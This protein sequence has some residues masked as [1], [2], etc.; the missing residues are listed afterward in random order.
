MRSSH[1][2]TLNVYGLACGCDVADL[3]REI[4][5]MNGVESCSVDLSTGKMQVVGGASQPEIE[6]RL[7][8]LGYS[9][10]P[11]V[12]NGGTSGAVS[13]VVDFWRHMMR[14]LDTRLAVLSFFLL[15]PTL[16]ISEVLRFGHFLIA[17]FYLTSLSLA[18]WPVARSAWRALFH[19]REVNINVLMTIAS[20]GAV[21]I[22]SLGEAAVVMV[23]FALG[24]A[25]E[26][27]TTHRARESIRSLMQ[28]VPNRATRLERHGVHEHHI[29]VD[30][31]DLRIGD[32]ILVKPGERIPIDGQVVQGLSAV[33][34]APITGEARLI[35]KSAGD[36]VFASSVNG[37]GALEVEVSRLAEDTTINRMIRLVDQA[38]EKRAPTQRFIDRF[39]KAYTPAMVLAAALVALVPP[40]L[41]GE[42]LLNPEGGG[43]GWLY[44]GLALLVVGC[45]CALVISTPVTIISAIASAARQG[46][47][48]KG[49]AQLEKLSAVRAVAFDKTGTLTLGEPAV[50]AVRSLDC[51]DRLAEGHVGEGG[52]GCRGCDEVVALASAVERKSQHPIAD[53]IVRESQRRRVADRYPAAVDVV[54]RTGQGVQ[55]LIDEGEVVVGNHRYF[56]ES[57][58]HPESHCRAARMDSS[59]GRTPVMVSRDG[60]YIGTIT[61]ADSLRH[62]GLHA[63][64]T[65]R[66]DGI[67][68]LVML[69]GDEATSA[70]LIADQVG[71][72]DV[73]AGLLPEEKLNAVERLQLEYGRVA[74]VGDG[75]NDAPALA[76]ADVG[77]A[78][79]AASTA[80]HQAIETADVA[81]MSA[82]LSRLGFL[83]RLGRRTLGVIRANIALS[84]GLKAV[85][86]V[87]VLIGS[88]TMWMAV[89]ADM[90]ASLLV[91]LNGMRLLRFREV[92]EPN[93]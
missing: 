42:P 19:H 22:G 14:R 40:F 79:G 49:G 7:Q 64:D 15:I 65:L 81:L 86:L 62:D 57:V 41:F 67:E 78:V 13:T 26:G 55:G 45:P 70:R 53:A 32:R 3:E 59:A 1:Q 69:T 9:T 44:R 74:M 54:A 61:L 77:I 16:L 90:G 11:P 30:V 72:K 56:D 24:E 8:T 46:V 33:N 84:L 87:L 39:A 28:V 31:E 37:E 83:F 36:E 18:G 27:Y 68:H 92:E 66:K 4:R 10:Q 75:I 60:A 58:P 29:R 6:R 25:L 34:Q 76:Y 23:L 88:G 73:R 89:M 21:V 20:I 47:L 5:N 80:T 85:F 17:A 52:G 35:E 51:D 63:L 93:P 2:I 43:F 91:T 82:D 71:L 12:S 48:I 38:Q 50:V